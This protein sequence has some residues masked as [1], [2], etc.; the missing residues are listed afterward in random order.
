MS[1]LDPSY[2]ATDYEKSKSD[3]DWTGFYGDVENTIPPNAPNIPD[4]EVELKI[5]VDS[6]HARGK[7]THCSCTGFMIFVNMSTINELSKK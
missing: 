3:Q 6:G 2:T 1:S 7:A 4:K 5:F